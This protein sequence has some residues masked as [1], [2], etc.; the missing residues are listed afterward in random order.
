MTNARL[1]R[2]AVLFIA[3]PW[4]PSVMLAQTVGTL[5]GTVHDPQGAVV[6]NANVVAVQ[7]A[8][9]T[10]RNV[11]TDSAG[12]YVIPLLPIGEYE[13]TADA[14]GFQ[15]TGAKVILEAQQT[16]RVDLALQIGTVAVETTVIAET[17]VL[18]ADTS[19]IGTVVDNQ[20]MVDLPMNGRNFIALNALDAGAATQAGA[21]NS[22]FVQLFGGNYSFNGSAGDS[23]TS[24]ID[25]VISK[26]MGDARITLQLS[27]DAI[28]EFNQQTSL[29]SA[30]FSGGGNV[31]VVDPQRNEHS[32]RES[33]GVFPEF[34]PRR[35]EL[36]RPEK[37]VAVPAESVRRH[38]GWADQARQD[39]LFREL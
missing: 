7:T 20:R 37:Y 32:A 26:G 12:N 35:A 6:A 18:K 9:S 16:A 17:P 15:K 19:D 24:S 27:I 4:I 34:R 13:V 33:V 39:V 11:K 22:Y 28:Q 2:F 31:N 1:R 14:P 36:L 30:Q 8:T 23:S 25:G 29:Y 5:T 10:T 3:V 21:R 38:G